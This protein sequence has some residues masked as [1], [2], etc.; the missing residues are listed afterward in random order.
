MGTAG[1]TG[2]LDTSM[3]NITRTIWLTLWFVIL[4]GCTTKELEP[5]DRDLVLKIGQLQ[6]YGLNLSG[7]YA[8]FESFTKQQWFDGTFTI[9]YEFQAAAHLRLPF[10]YSIAETHASNIEACVSYSAGNV[11]LPLGLGDV[12]L[13][14]RDDLFAFGDK[15]RF[16]LLM[17]DGEPAG[18]YFAMC[19]ERTSLMIVLSGFYFDNGELW[20]EL[21]APTLDA[22]SSVHNQ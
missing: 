11:G 4:T 17:V 21:L 18:N 1:G 10:L 2:L 3:R 6:E 13:S 5:G 22:L 8:V 12:E 7:N 15:S 19:H 16:G 9:E 20:G 14:V